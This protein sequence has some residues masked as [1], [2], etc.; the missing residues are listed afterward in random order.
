MTAVG[1]RFDKFQLLT[2]VLIGGS[3][4]I[5]TP[6]RQGHPRFLDTMHHTISFVYPKSLQPRTLFILLMVLGNET[7]DFSDLRVEH[8]HFPKNLMRTLRFEAEL[9]VI[10]RSTKKR[11]LVQAGESP[12]V[13]DAGWWEI[14]NPSEE[15]EGHGREKL[16]KARAHQT[17]VVANSG[18]TKQ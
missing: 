8:R 5:S 9:K 14:S 11:R 2:N 13:H 7:D 4:N 12:T 10:S 15:L 1:K 16:M 18:P 17:V 3:K 6:L